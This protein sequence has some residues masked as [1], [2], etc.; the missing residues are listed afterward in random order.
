M[1]KT[2]S[3]LLLLL[4]L[5]VPIGCQSLWYQ[6]LNI[7]VDIAPDRFVFEKNHEKLSIP[8]V[9]SLPLDKDGNEAEYL[10]IMI[11]GAGLNAGNMFE[12]GQ[13]IIDALN[14]PKDRFCVIAP[15]IIEGVKLEERG[16]LF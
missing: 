10:M 5:L 13:Q 9:T 12:T 2:A 1:S 16:L 6:F 7:V 3:I 14:L 15:Q 4:T 11:H 8:V